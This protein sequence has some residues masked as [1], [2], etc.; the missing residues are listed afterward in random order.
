M[1]LGMGL[2][3]PGSMPAPTAETSH[4]TSPPSGSATA[5]L[6]GLSSPLANAGLLPA[7]AASEVAV[8]NVTL[9]ARPDNGA[10]TWSVAVTP[11]LNQAPT[12]GRAETHLHTQIDASQL[13]QPAGHHHT[14]AGAA[15]PLAPAWVTALQTP[16]PHLGP[17]P[18]AHSERRQGRGQPD[19][20]PAEAQSETAPQDT[21][22]ERPAQASPADEDPAPASWPPSFEALLPP[23]VR[24]ELALRRSVLVVAPPGAGQRGLQLACLG[25]D[26][27]GQ[28]ACHR[29]AVRGAVAATDPG[30]D[31]VFWRVRR[32]G[33]DGQ[34]PLLHARL[35]R[36]SQTAASGLVLRATATVLPPPLRPPAHAW[37][38]VLEP[39]RL[40]R[41]LGSQW[42]LLLA[43]SPHALPLNTP[44]TRP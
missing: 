25:F 3:A 34:R 37:L 40:W 2:P 21:A 27:R 39:Q 26:S 5:I 30:C 44:A 12:V 35:L 10:A 11:L 38:D 4:P 41:H 28:P 42:T 32:E 9:S 13:A 24:A 31:W 33:D 20:D 16:A 18:Q 14:E 6:A 8:A 15:L 1:G 29:W 36:P 17:L 43:W 19:R 7:A 23:E 22:P